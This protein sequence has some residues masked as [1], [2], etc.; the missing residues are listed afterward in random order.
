MSRYSKFVIAVIG[1]L[2]TWATAALSVEETGG[3]VVTEAEWVALGIGLL[4]AAGVYLKAN[5]PPEGEQAD[6][7]ISERDAVNPTPH[8]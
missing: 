2:T 6:P 7:N 1:V 5:T 8:W 3:V 4:T